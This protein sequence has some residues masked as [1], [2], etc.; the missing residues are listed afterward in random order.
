V[1]ADEASMPVALTLASEALDVETAWVLPGY[2][3]LYDVC[4]ASALRDANRRQTCSAAAELLV[5]RADTLLERGVGVALGKRLGWSD[6]RV[7]RLQGEADAY[8]ASLNA[9]VP[10]GH[11]SNCAEI[12]R[13]LSIVQRHVRLGE[14]GGLRE[15]VA[16]SGRTAEDFIHVHRES[17]RVAA[18]AAVSA[19]SAA[20]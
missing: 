5:E 2:T 3:A 16:R 6:E 13:D 18:A 7:D 9:F 17:A 20:R 12:R 15:W 8:S 11:V 4:K 10:G 14:A 1:P 19:A